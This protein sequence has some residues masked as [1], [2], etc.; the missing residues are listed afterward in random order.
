MNDLTINDV[1]KLF[2]NHFQELGYIKLKNLWYKNFDNGF[3]GY[4]NIIKSSHG[5]DFYLHYDICV[6]DLFEES[7]FPYIFKKPLMNCKFIKLIFDDKD[8]QQF[9]KLRDYENIK[10]I[11]LQQN[12]DKYMNILYKYDAIQFCE[13]LCDYENLK[14]Y[15]ELENQWKY[16]I[17]QFATSKQVLDFVNKKISLK[18]PLAR[19]GL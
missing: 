10:E 15:I 14:E 17:F 6:E 1:R 3:Y 8:K 9:M 5:K 19:V 4:F 16:F 13:K 7:S 12:I 11:E 2:S 18:S